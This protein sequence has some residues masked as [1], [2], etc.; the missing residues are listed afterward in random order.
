[1]NRTERAAEAAVI[2]ERK[3]EHILLALSPLAD[4]LNK[5]TLLEE[6]E[7]VH[8]A[9][10]E[11]GVDDVDLG[12]TLLG[13]KLQ[14]PIVIAGMTGGTAQ[15]R[16]INC[17]LARAAELLGLGFGLG[18]QRA[19]AVKPRLAYTYQVRDAAPTALVLGNLGLVQA[20]AM[21]TPA[22]RKLC[23]QV[24]ADAL[25]IHLNPTQE[26]VQEGGDH[27]FQGGIETLQRLERELSLPIVVKE[28]GCGLSRQAGLMIQ[29]IGITAVDVSGSGGT[30]WPGIEAM[31]AKGSAAREL[32][33]ILWDWGIPTA[34]SVA[35]LADLEFT[36]IATGGIR[37]GLDIAKAIALGA[38]AGGM[39]KPVL[40]AYETLG[41]LGVV[42]F[43][44]RIIYQ[45]KTVMLLT[46]SR[47]ISDLR[48]T[49]RLLGPKLRAWMEQTR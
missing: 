33:A 2:E 20:R 34:A 35:M 12:V 21:S 4:A 9:L 25:C 15:A 45:L 44:Q 19:M 32:G 14:A 30:S 38:S 26:L 18:S 13:K 24:G 40:N 48:K 42:E 29:K 49:R 8:Q 41:Y 27:N 7:F 43:L 11:I 16:E 37:T 28:T 1:M 22:V 23:A 39:A 31:R 3:R 36:I 6:V 46:G 5:T 47:D 10:P 17:D